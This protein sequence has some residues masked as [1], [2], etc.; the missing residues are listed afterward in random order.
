[1]KKK[2]NY[3]RLVKRVKYK[4]KLTNVVLRKF[5]KSKV[6][7][8][9]GLEAYNKKSN[10]YTDKTDPLADLIQRTNKYL[11][12]LRLIKWITQKQYEHLS[13]K[14]DTPLRP[15]VSGRKHPAI[16]ISKFL[17]ELLQPLFNQMASK[18]TVTSG[19]ELVKYVRELFKINLRQDT[20]FCTVDVTDVYTMVPQLEGVLSL[21]KMLD[22]LKL[23]QIGGLKIETI[24]RLS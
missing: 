14:P 17:D 10:E 24:I 21:K 4:F 11:L 1:M 18:T 23:K 9:G 16:Q 7:H 3:G 8:L 12:D 15:I 22:Y 6:F 13:H 5:D 20:L 2:R 19:F